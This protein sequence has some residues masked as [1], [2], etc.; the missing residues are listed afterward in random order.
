MLHKHYIE[1]VNK[2]PLILIPF[3]S[4]NTSIG[5][6]F[7]CGYFEEDNKVKGIT[8]FLEHL[9]GSNIRECKLMKKLQKKGKFL[10]CNAYTGKFNT[11]YYI[12]TQPNF[13]LDALDLLIDN[14]F[15]FE[16]NLDTYNRE[17]NSIIFEMIKKRNS[18]ND[19]SYLE[20]LKSFYINKSLIRDPSVHINN[21]SNLTPLVIN[22]FYNKYYKSN[23]VILVSGK[24]VKNIVLDRLKEKKIINNSIVSIN[25]NIVLRNN[26]SYKYSFIYDKN[27]SLVK[28]IYNFRIFNSESNKKYYVKMI[29][30][31]LDNIGSES[32]LFK[33][34]RIK[35][36]ITYSPHSK[37]EVNKYFG[38]MSINI[39]TIKK[40]LEIVKSEINQILYSLKNIL[41]SKYLIDLGISKMKYDILNLKNNL[42]SKNYIKYGDKFINKMKIEN[43]LEVYNVYKKITPKNLLDISNEIFNLNNLHIVCIYK[44]TIPDIFKTLKF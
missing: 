8:H 14:V 39:S 31:I 5:I 18:P 44:Y 2:I 28:L 10:N 24:F 37:I 34:F 26:K 33:N 1:K 6:T 19:K 13:F 40:N 30:T 27:S 20:T 22:K 12:T 16:I 23:F 4:N 29:S 11:T 38:I 42:D 3:E 36:G 17:R 25:R 41:L 7:K 21:I 35:L 15:N 9:I 32:I 43:P